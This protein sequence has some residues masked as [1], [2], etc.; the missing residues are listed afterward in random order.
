MEIILFRHGHAIDDTGSPALGDSARWLSGKGRE[1]TRATAK[2]LFSRKKRRPV[3]VWTSPLVRAVQTEEIL[4]EAL[5]LKGEV[6]V[7]DELSPGHEPEEIV[8][9][10]ALYTGSG[11]LMLVGHE[12]SLST[13]AAFLLGERSFP[14]LKKSGAI[15]LS[16][17]GKGRG[18]AKIVFEQQPKG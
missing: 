6:F 3:E 17:E 13:L 2:K 15:G 10:L 16:W 4:V 12:P 11:P 14:S 18:P 1:R 5:G 9:R 8:D 7:K